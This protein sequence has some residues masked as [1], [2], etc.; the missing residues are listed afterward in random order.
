MEDDSAEKNIDIWTGNGDGGTK[1]KK[2]Q[3]SQK[4]FSD[5]D[6]GDED[7]PDDDGDQDADTLVGQSIV[8]TKMPS[9][10]EAAARKARIEH[11]S[12]TVTILVSRKK[13]GARKTAVGSG[14]VVK[15]D[16]INGRCKVMTCEHVLGRFIDKS[17]KYHLWVR[18]F[19]GDEDALATV[20]FACDHMDI[21]VLDAPH[22]PAR[23]GT[24][25]PTIL[26]FSKKKKIGTD[27]VLLGYFNPP[28][29]EQHFGK[30]SVIAKDPNSIP[31]KI[32]GPLR[33]Y[34]N[35]PDKV[36]FP[37]SCYGI[38]ESSGSP[39]ISHE[40]GKVLGIFHSSD[41]E[42]HSAIA[43]IAVKNQL[44]LWLRAEG[45]TSMKDLIER[46]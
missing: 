6:D 29:I 15:L 22:F 45:T 44:I 30:E 28:A 42:I 26:E 31:G 12:A 27:I 23:P 9:V 20:Q 41:D 5:A 36:T 46:L 4:F 40:S 17:H 33:Y 18:Y 14:F 19:R 1:A 39:I 24:T 3:R 32:T 11:S 37:H 10:A 13:A 16:K 38:D 35:V 2:L 7:V 25:P 21:A 43:T 8:N 34:P